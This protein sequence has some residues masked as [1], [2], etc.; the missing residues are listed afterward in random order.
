MAVHLYMAP[1]EGLTDRIFRKTFTQFFG[2]FDKM[3]TPFFS[4]NDENPYKINKLR[5]QLADD[6]D[7]ALIVPQAL[8]NS[9]EA[10]LYFQETLAKMGYWRFN[11]NLGCPYRVVVNKN[12]GAGLLNQPVMLEKIIKDIAANASLPFSV[13]VRLGMQNPEE[14][15]PIIDIFNRYKIEEIIIHPRTGNNYYQGIPDQE[16]FAECVR[17]S[18]HPVVYN[19]DIFSVIDFQSIINLHPQIATFML[20]RGI[21]RNPFLANQI[22]GVSPPSNKK[23]MLFNFQRE[24]FDNLYRERGK[25]RYFPHGIKEFWSYL[26]N[27]FD[28]SEAVF[29]RIKRVNSI[30]EY[31]EVTENIFQTHNLKI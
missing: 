14:I 22:K 25:G 11:L 10:I 15:L 23:E 8:S 12:K 19:G 31:Y 30:N 6:C 21:L 29:D 3:F 2:G 5:K 27:S 24:L 20:G 4:F 13:K 1:L 17:R 28:G 16:R 18:E 26:S 9:P 7:P